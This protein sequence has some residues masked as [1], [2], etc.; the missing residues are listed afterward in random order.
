ME[1]TRSYKKVVQ[2]EL[3]EIS[4]DAIKIMIDR[5]QM[6]NF[7][8]VFEQWQ[9]VETTSEDV[10]AQI[11]PWIQWVTVHTGKS[12]QEHE[13][14]R[15]G[16]AHDLKH[17]Q[18][19]E[20]LSDRGISSAIVGA[21][22]A[23]RG[24]LNTGV[25]FPDPWSKENS[26]FPQSLQGLWKL[27]S[28]RVQS[29]A[30]SQPSVW[31]AWEALSATRQFKISPWVFAR[32]GKQIASQAINPKRK[33][34]LVGLFDLFLAE[35]FINI[36]R[37]PQYRFC[38]LFLNS[39]AHYQHHF[40]RKF[41]ASRFDTRIQCPDCEPGDDP[42]T[43]GYEM[44]DEVLGRVLQSIDLETT[45]VLIVSGLSQIP[46]TRHEAQGGMNYYRLIDHKQ[47]AAQ[48]GFRP[49]QI[50]PLMSRDW[51]I[52]VL[53]NISADQIVQTLSKVVVDE[54]QL[55]R[56]EQ[57]T[58][59]Y[60]FVETAITDLVPAAS[61]VKYADRELGRFA[62]IFVNIAIKSGH[63][64]GIGSVWCNHKVFSDDALRI[65]LTKVF[66]VGMNALI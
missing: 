15:L 30:A 1:N 4:R 38:S 27:V 53:G 41:D 48:L 28:A 60:I 11:E 32:I 13:I 16:D 63:H 43:F 8:R 65:P 51:Q 61:V 29:H 5:G 46:D 19:W 62:D 56:V 52:K 25:F 45:L 20:I 12:F 66:D 33:W 23:R 18:I 2:L 22:N 14:F 17:D 55:F 24:R 58:D 36:L 3:N 44:M 42:M 31:D 21:M 7:R 50:F 49:E 59:G 47:F 37:E 35:L 40:W 34:K 57:N 64:T 54:K 6:P 26:A 39:V 10:Y 9:Y